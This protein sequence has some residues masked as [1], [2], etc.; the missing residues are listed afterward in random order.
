MKSESKLWPSARNS[1]LCVCH[2]GKTN[3]PH[4]SGEAEITRAAHT[5]A[6][7]K[8]EGDQ[9]LASSSWMGFAHLRGHEQCAHKWLAQGAH[10]GWSVQTQPHKIPNHTKNYISSL[11]TH[12]AQSHHQLEERCSGWRW[13]GVEKGAEEL[14]ISKFFLSQNIIF[15]LKFGIFMSQILLHWEQWIK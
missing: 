12:R 4:P 6:C 1:F 13:P 14:Y 5:F 9:C 2:Q 3:F 11:T 10:S 15:F 7:S 8:G